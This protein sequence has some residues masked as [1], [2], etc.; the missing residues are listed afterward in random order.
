MR[1]KADDYWRRIQAFGNA[2]EQQLAEQLAA[3]YEAAL[4]TAIHKY[5]DF[6]DKVSDVRTGLYKPPQ[7]YLDKGI[8]A[9][10]RWRQG[11]ETELL[12]RGDVVE[13][14][15]RELM[16]AGYQ[17][18]THIRAAMADIY[19]FVHAETVGLLNAQAGIDLGITG[20]NRDTARLLY[21]AMETPLTKLAY[22]RYTDVED[23]EQRL[24]RE[25]NTA[26]STGESTRKLS[27]RIYEQIK[28]QTS[29]EY[30]RTGRDPYLRACK[31]LASYEAACA[32]RI[33]QTERTRVQNQC[34]YDVGQRAKEKGV[35]IYH[36]WSCQM[37]PP[38]EDGRGGSRATHKALHGQKRLQGVP[39]DLIDGD[40][41]LY[42]GDPQ[43]RARNIIN[44]HCGLIPHVLLPGETLE[45]A[46]A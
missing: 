31:S 10:E 30:F 35:Q 1:A 33:A 37:I 43:G 7:Y 18:P 45:E 41:L 9:V 3:D 29:E 6:F 38:G 21:Q 26:I 23:M 24:R 4:M 40:R 27:G 44:C 2:R 32:R 8:D 16:Q 11:F 39:F 25:F 13:G 17:V 12:R 15:A 36:T 34:C 19:T 42:P 20:I 22:T 5:K 28:G 46:M 14:I